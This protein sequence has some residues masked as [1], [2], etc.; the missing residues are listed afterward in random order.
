MHALTAFANANDVAGFSDWRSI[1]ALDYRA[2]SL[3]LVF[4]DLIASIAASCRR[5]RRGREK[6]FE[7]RDRAT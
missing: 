1:R 7:R 3:I 2:R 4:I 5:E 6:M